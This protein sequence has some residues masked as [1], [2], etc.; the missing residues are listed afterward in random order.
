MKRI[1]FTIAALYI[2][3]TIGCRKDLEFTTDGN[4]KL[5]FS[6]DTLRFDTVFTEIGSATRILKVY[7]RNKKAIRISRIYVEEG[8]DTKFRFNVDGIAAGEFKDV[9]ILAEDSIYI[10]G[11]VTV[12]PDEPLSVSPFVINDYLHFEYNGND[13]KVTLEAFG[14]NAN[15]IPDHYSKDK[16]SLLSCDF[17]EITWDDPKPYV[18][19]GILFIDS[20]QLNI[21]EGTQVFVHGGIVKAN[22]NG[23]PTIYNSGMIYTLPDGKINVTGTL[24]NPVVFQGDRLEEEYDDKPGQWVGIRCGKMSVGNRFEHTIIKNSTVGIYADSVSS[25]AVT[26]TQIYN[27]SSVGMAGIHASITADNCL[28]YNNYGGGLRLIHGGNYDFNYCTIGS[29]GI[30]AAALGMSNGICYDEPSICEHNSVYP[31]NAGFTDC[32]VMGTGKDEIDLDDFLGGEDPAYFNYQFKNCIV[33]V[34]KLLTYA[35]GL[36]QDFFDA[37]CENCIN[38][39]NQDALFYNTDDDDYHLDTLSIAEEKAIPLP[40]ITIDLE[41]NT[42]DAAKPDLGCFEYLY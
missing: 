31:L 2:V 26:N 23:E 24:E 32:I 5:E 6:L 41:G 20:C 4:D 15:Y 39:K 14:Q 3:F 21:P 7:N 10:F 13:D 36:Y 29:Y 9:E 33:K 19:Y 8:A 22:I 35:N 27:T 28:L 12:D 34:D 40:D 11:E 38:A 1:I 17:G 25:V 18:I 37:H 16:L 42:R 30:Q